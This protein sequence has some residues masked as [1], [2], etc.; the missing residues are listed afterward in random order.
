MKDACWEWPGNKNYAGY[1][2][3]R[4][5]GRRYTFVHRLSAQMY[6][7]FDIKSKL[8]VLH[9]CDNP[10]CFNPAHLFVG[11]RTDNAKDRTLKNHNR[12]GD[13][14]G[15]AKLNWDKIDDIRKQLRRGKT[16]RW[17]AK[18]YSVTQSLISR[19]KLKKNW[20]RKELVLAG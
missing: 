8:C 14:N 12:F 5:Q 19:I 16:Q 11:T 10:P 6:L 17:L 18:Q 3:I 4:L 13:A 7:G 20:R 9:K 1:G 2:R 15:M